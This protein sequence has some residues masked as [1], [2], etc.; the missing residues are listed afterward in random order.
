[1][2]ALGLTATALFL[3]KT[4]SGPGLGNGASWTTN[5]PPASKSQTAELEEGMVAKGL[6]WETLNGYKLE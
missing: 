5:C 3:I 6:Y 2:N 4:S 1:M